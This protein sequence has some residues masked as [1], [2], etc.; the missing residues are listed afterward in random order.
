MVPGQ[1][2]ATGA[3]GRCEAFPFTRELFCCHSDGSTES[4]HQKP[5]YSC[6][7]TM[8]TNTSDCKKHITKENAILPRRSASTN[9][10]IL[11]S[12]HCQKEQLFPVSLDA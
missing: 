5:Q 1:D 2:G 8:L 11:I 10:Y 3:S 9:A 7:Y 4:F 12:R 6:C